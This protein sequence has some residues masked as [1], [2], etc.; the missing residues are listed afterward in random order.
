M[1]VNIENPV[2]TIL[3]GVG[4]FYDS[5]SVTPKYLPLNPNNEYIEILFL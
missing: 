2:G 1:K 4:L 5:N 3:Q